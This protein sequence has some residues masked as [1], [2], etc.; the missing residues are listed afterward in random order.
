MTPTPVLQEM[1]RARNILYHNFR[2]R[3]VSRAKHLRRISVS[4]LGQGGA[5]CAFSLR[6]GHGVC[7]GET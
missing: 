2:S 3:N 5:R 6:G 7:H 1:F 4:V